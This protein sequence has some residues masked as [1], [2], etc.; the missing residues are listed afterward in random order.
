VDGERRFVWDRTVQ[1]HKVEHGSSRSDAMVVPLDEANPALG[2]REPPHLWRRDAWPVWVLGPGVVASRG[3][4]GRSP[5]RCRRP[6]P[7]PGALCRR[8]VAL[9]MTR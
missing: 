3:R 1:M 2:Y 9:A 8:R 7:R 4:A 6:C 5:D